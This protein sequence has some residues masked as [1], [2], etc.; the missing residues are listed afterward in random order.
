MLRNRNGFSLI[1]FLI[2]L[3]IIASLI[4]IV[5]P[6]SL[7]YIRKAK[8]SAVANDLKTL[9]KGFMNYVY[10][11]DEYPDSLNEFSRN[12]NSDRYGIAYDENGNYV[13]YTNDKVNFN[14]LH[15][16][17]DV[18]NT[19]GLSDEE[20]II[21]L[22]IPENGIFYYASLGINPYNEENETTNTENI[23]LS[24]DSFIREN[25]FPIGNFSK[26][27][28]SGGAFRSNGFW[29]SEF[30]K[31]L[32]NG[33][34]DGKNN[35]GI[36]NSNNET[37]NNGTIM[38]SGNNLDYVKQYS[39]SNFAPYAVTVTKITPQNGESLEEA[40]NR[41]LN[42]SGYKKSLN[43]TIILNCSDPVNGPIEVYEGEY[44]PETDYLSL[45]KLGSRYR[46]PS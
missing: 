1:E 4:A 11:M 22:S 12:V 19:N 26:G 44:D 29:D 9:S 23:P 30:E 20:S 40:F 18:T 7:N 32:Q 43:G 41:I 15:N 3:A 34:R 6:I 10:T 24:L 42:T 25:I 37:Q 27:Y 28:S 17:I 46:L 8:S 33:V 14:E 36:I 5:T 16:L 38:Y 31:Y 39:N 21:G 2:V 13:V 35:A 45:T